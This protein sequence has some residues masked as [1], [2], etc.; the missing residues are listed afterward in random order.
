[1]KVLF[2]TDTHSDKDLIGKIK[3]KSLKADMLVCLGDLTTFQAYMKAILKDLNGIGKPLLIIPGNH[4]GDDALKDACEPFKNIVYLHKNFYETDSCIFLGFGGGGFM[5]RD[6]EFE[7]F[8]KKWV[9]KIDEA[10]DKKVI[11][12]THGPPY[13]CS[14]DIVSKNH[15]GNMSY[16]SFIKKNKVDFVFSGH[17]HENFYKTGKIGKAV[18]MNPGP[19]GRI[20]NI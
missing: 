19:E 5:L 10:K 6:L 15:V 13:G 4:E 16:T 14:I 3:E 2:F 1:M 18:V 9:K 11:L 7:R 8:S 20:V 17:L 12:L